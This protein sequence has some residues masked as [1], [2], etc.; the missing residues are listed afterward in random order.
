MT[1]LSELCRNPWTHMINYCMWCVCFAFVS[2]LT[3]KCLLSMSLSGANVVQIQK[4]KRKNSPVDPYF[5]E[6][7]GLADLPPSM[8]QFSSA[9]PSRPV[10]LTQLTTKPPRPQ[11]W[12]LSAC[13][14]HAALKQ[15]QWAPYDPYPSG[16]QEPS[17]FKGSQVEGDKNK[18]TDLKS[19]QQQRWQCA[20][21]SPQVSQVCVNISLNK[22][23]WGIVKAV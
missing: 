14:S 23:V 11:F 3:S 9:T 7:D 21:L 19:N 16:N 6:C 18:G 8:K 4:K 17:R 1:P 15:T 12:A 5:R 10:C 20:A 2:I 22:P 13:V